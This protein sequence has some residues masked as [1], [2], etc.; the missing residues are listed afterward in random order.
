MG[1]RLTLLMAHQLEK[2]PQLTEEKQRRG[3]LGLR[4][5][6]VLFRVGEAG[7]VRIAQPMS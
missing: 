5:L 7:L 1:E 2:Y 6:S 3:S 4:G